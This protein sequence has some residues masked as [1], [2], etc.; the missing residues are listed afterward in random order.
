MLVVLSGRSGVGKTT[1]ARGLAAAWPAVHLR[2]DSIEQ[3]LRRGGVEVYAEAY[4]VAHA[5]AEDNLRLG[6]RVI[7]DSVNPWPLTR[8][9][10]RAVAERA[11]VPVLDVEV[12]C[13]DAAEHQRRV[14]SRA[15]DIPGHVVPTWREVLARDYRPWDTERLVVDSALLTVKESVALIVAEAPSRM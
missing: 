12:V 14:E 1:I 2:I 9:E 5:V 15:S 7:A 8:V 6:S 3:A 13:S 10:W 4:A 11:G